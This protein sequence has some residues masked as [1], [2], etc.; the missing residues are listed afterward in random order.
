MKI[1]ELAEAS[2][3]SVPTIKY[4]IRAKLLPPGNSVAKTQARY[5][6]T[7]LKRLDLI[8]TLQNE[9]GMSVEK[10]AQVLAEAEQG[11]VALLSAGLKGARESR[12][13][14]KKLDQSSPEM[15]KA[16][17]LLT[18]LEKELGWDISPEHPSA[19]DVAEAVATILR[20]MPD[21]KVDESLIEYATVMKSVA[22]QEIPDSFDPAGDPWESLRYAVLGTY[23]FE[24]LI[25]GLRRMA[26]GQRTAEI[27]NDRARPPGAKK[28]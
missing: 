16:W 7:H 28:G 14:A 11:G 17:K 26:H 13:G 21:A 20:V 25:L 15:G 9:L 4:Y 3:Q 12:H 5:D 2:G 24:P 6:Q 1:S 18:Q 22:D 10:I 23:L 27:M 8:R 19:G